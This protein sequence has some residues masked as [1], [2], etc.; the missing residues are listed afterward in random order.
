MEPNSKILVGVDISNGDRLAEG[1]ISGPNLEAINQSILVAQTAN[2]EITFFTAIEISEQAQHLFEI[3]EH[4]ITE[5]VMDAA[6]EILDRFIAQAKESGVKADKKIVFGKAYVEMIREVIKDDMSLLVMGT[7]ERSSAS[8]LIFG[9]TAMQVLRKCPCP[10]WVTRPDPEP[11]VQNILVMDGLDDTGEVALDYGVRA[12]QVFDSNLH[13]VNAIEYPLS[14]KLLRTNMTP[15]EIVDYK[16]KIHEKVEA[17][18]TDRLLQTDARTLEKG[19]MKHVIAGPTD[20]VV[21]D[22]IEKQEIDLLIMGTLGRCGIPGIIIG[23]T[24]EKLLSQIDISLLA[25]KPIGYRSP[26]TVD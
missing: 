2:A 18:L 23:N 24:A 25:V 10:V 14:E 13:V 1:H 7:R 5:T 19:V 26:I 17:Q 4:S 16:K 21:V 3:G 6:N 22:L 9:S 11:G 20:Q 8:R 12:A 15:D